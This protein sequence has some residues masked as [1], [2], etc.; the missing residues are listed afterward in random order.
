MIN[1]KCEYNE[2]IKHM[3]IT[4]Y[5]RLSKYKS[6]KLLKYLEPVQK[7]IKMSYINTQYDTC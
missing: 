6:S 1:P 3:K 7:Y 2:D 5:N 4:N